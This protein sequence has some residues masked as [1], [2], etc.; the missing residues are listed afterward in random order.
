MY[1]LENGVVNIQNW[2]RN[3]KIIIPFFKVFRAE[4]VI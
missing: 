3:L 2:I 1:E 4:E